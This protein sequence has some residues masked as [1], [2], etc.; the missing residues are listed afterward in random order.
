SSGISLASFHR[1]KQ[2]FARVLRCPD[3]RIAGGGLFPTHDRRLLRFHKWMR[4]SACAWL[5]AGGL[6]EKVVIIGGS[7]RG[8]GGS[9]TDELELVRIDPKFRFHFEA[10][11]KRRPRIL[12]FQH[13]RLFQYA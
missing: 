12:E 9:G 11:L 7:E 10:V 1:V 2:C 6:A 5:G 8:V 4:S 13:L 3:G